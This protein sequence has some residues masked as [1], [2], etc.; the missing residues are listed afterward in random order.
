MSNLRRSRPYEQD[1][2]LRRLQE[3]AVTR[4]RLDSP[5]QQSPS[6]P[7][8]F[9][10][11][12]DL[13]DQDIGVFT[14]GDISSYQETA[15]LVFLP[16][17]TPKLVSPVSPKPRTILNLDFSREHSPSESDSESSSPCPR[18]VHS[19]N[20]GR[21]QLS[22]TDDNKW[23]KLHSLLVAMK[24]EPFDVEESL[25]SSTGFCE[26]SSAKP[27]TQEELQMELAVL[28]DLLDDKRIQL[29]QAHLERDA[30]LT[31]IH[32]SKVNGADALAADEP[33]KEVIDLYKLG[34][35]S[36]RE[37]SVSKESVIELL[38]PLVRE[39]HKQKAYLDRL[40]TV[41]LMRAPWILEEVDKI[42]LP[43]CE[44]PVFSMDKQEEEWR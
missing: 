44:S 2:L 5:D 9:A 30:A 35:D 3:I 1:D 39:L 36:L 4:H 6:S 31:Y 43:D 10:H 12:S 21:L 11:L 8:R 25:K 34:I 17:S 14:P 23:Q 24:D 29:Q 16:E 42:D 19:F 32:R 22:L 27:S 41:T 26:R 28:Q 20:V 37:P 40:V 13:E 15:D 33:G 38:L 7:R 18:D